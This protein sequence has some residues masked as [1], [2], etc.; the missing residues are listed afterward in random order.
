M[1]HDVNEPDGFAAAMRAAEERAVAPVEQPEAD[2]EQAAP[3]SVGRPGPEEDQ[4]A[5]DRVARLEQQLEDAQKMIGRQ[6]NEIGDLR[7]EQDQWAADEQQQSAMVTE[8]TWENI[9]EIFETKGGIGLMAQVSHQQPQ[10]IDAALSFWKAQGDPEAFLYETQMR[11]LEQQIREQQ[12]AE[13]GPDP[14]V[15]A[16][17]VER[18]QEA[19]VAA[20]QREIGAERV[21]A[22]EPYLRESLELA[23]PTL[24]R[25]MEEDFTSGDPERTAQAFK[26]LISLTEARG[27]PEVSSLAAEQRAAANRT[28]KIAAAAHTG[29]RREA[30]AGESDLPATLEEM[31]ALGEPGSQARRA[32]AAQIMGQRILEGQTS[33][34]AEL[35]RSEREA[36]Q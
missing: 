6:S 10:M 17:R 9:Q 14:T 27:N 24:K 36:R 28:A 16:M 32:A 21:A 35:S 30:S 4:E 26:T 29:S 23:T 18:A 7:R 13:A 11:D 12:A 2:G 19:A 8:D 25:A 34:A 1:E 33:V 5:E 20:V 31:D 15:E 3:P 22:A